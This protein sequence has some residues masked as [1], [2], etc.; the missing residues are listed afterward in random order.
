[1]DDMQARCER[2]VARFRAAVEQRGMFLTPDERVN[3]ADAAELLGYAVGS[4]RNMRSAGGGPA[5][6]NRPL[7][8]FSKSYPWTTWPRGLSGPG[9]RPSK[10]ASRGRIR[11]H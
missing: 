11:A 1:M 8:S 9:R 4:L 7:G 2:L 10:K 5:F 3:E 6:F